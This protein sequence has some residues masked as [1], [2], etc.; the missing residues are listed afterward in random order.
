M[1]VPPPLLCQ[2]SS[3]LPCLCPQTLSPWAACQ[4]QILNAS[5]GVLRVTWVGVLEPGLQTGLG[6]ERGTVPDPCPCP[7]WLGLPPLPRLLHL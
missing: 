4:L 1:P 5:S 7:S 2:L 3:D 6:P